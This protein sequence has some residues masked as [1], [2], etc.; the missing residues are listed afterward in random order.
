[1]RGFGF[2]LIT[3]A[4]APERL[5]DLIDPA[6]EGWTDNPVHVSWGVLQTRE[7]IVSSI[8]VYPEPSPAWIFVFL[9]FVLIGLAITVIRYFST[10]ERDIELGWL[11]GFSLLGAFIL[12]A[13]LSIYYPFVQEPS[14]EKDLQAWK[15]RRDQWVSQQPT[16]PYSVIDKQIDAEGINAVIQT[17]KPIQ[18]VRVVNGI[19]YDSPAGEVITATWVDP[20]IPEDGEGYWANIGLHYPAQDGTQDE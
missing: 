15:D 11:G 14:Y 8:P 12:V 10:P 9:A 1:M 7:D 3:D 16:V 2:G 18:Q 4:T 6:P 19:T 5:L 17:S 13:A 20:F